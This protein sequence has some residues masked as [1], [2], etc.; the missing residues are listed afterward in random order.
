MLYAYPMDLAGCGHYRM[1]HPHNALSP[2]AQAKVKIVP[3]G[4]D[5][6]VQALVRNHKVL[7]VSVPSD[8]ST[9]L[10]QRP[11]SR[12]LYQTLFALAQDGVEIIMDVDDDLEALGPQHPT[13][14]VLQRSYEHDSI[15]PR[16]TAAFASRVIVSTDAL[17]ETYRAFNP[18]AEIVVCRNRIPASRILTDLPQYSDRTIGWPGAVATHPG[19]LE[20]LRG[21]AT[22]LGEFTIV[23]EEDPGAVPG[24]STD[25]TY[26]GRVEFAEWIPALAKHLSV[27]VVPLR[28]TRF[29]R[30]KSALKAMELAAAGVPMVRN[31][32]PEFERLGIGLGADKPRKWLTIGTKL[33]FDQLAWEDEQARNLEII[34]EETYEKHIAEWA[35]AWGL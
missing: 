33:R 6:G 14:Q 5:G 15:Y 20:E 10:V 22:A 3:P 2:D 29:N 18:S 11:T 1:I 16:M 9:V 27:A 34:K 31:K 30:A 21:A 12:V 35:Q 23:G 17:A 28:D 32:L 13:W 25:V 7:S 8:C 4:D 19:D 26:T 24:I